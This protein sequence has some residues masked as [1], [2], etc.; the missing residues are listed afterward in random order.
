MSQLFVPSSLAQP[1][2]QEQIAQILAA[3]GAS[4][5][6]SVKEKPKR[7]IGFVEAAARASSIKCGDS[8]VPVLEICA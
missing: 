6:K 3:F 2:Q 5:Q 8:Y 7:K 1:S 4:Q